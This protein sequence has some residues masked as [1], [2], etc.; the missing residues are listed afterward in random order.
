M[1]TAGDKGIPQEMLDKSQ[2]AVIVPSMKQGEFIVG[3]KFGRGFFTCRHE[4]GRG[5]KCPAAIRV[6]G[7]SVGFQI[8]GS[9]TD[10]I[11]LVKS[12][13]G[14]DKLA[15]SRF[16]IGGEVSAAAGPVGR[17]SNAMTDAQMS[18]EILSWSRSRSVFAG[19]S[20]QGA[21]LRED[22]QANTELYGKEMTTP[23]VLDR[24][25]AQPAAVQ[26]LVAA[27]TKFSGRA[28]K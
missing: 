11:M 26:P 18:A 15:G 5:W 20:V 27:L 8:G 24:K 21:T 4:N 25:E 14:G 1:M 22:Q 7:G 16:T 13:K 10:V 2:C 12:A 9:A 23:Q 17:E 3:G 28:G 6:E 19:V